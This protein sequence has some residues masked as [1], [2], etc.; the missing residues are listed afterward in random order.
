[1]VWHQNEERERRENRRRRRRRRKREK[2]DWERWDFGEEWVGFCV[3]GGRG[4]A[5][6]DAGGGRDQTFSSV[7]EV[8]ERSDLVVV[9][10]V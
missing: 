5:D 1:M 8:V 3:A 4:D 9:E 6:G 7:K 10:R 2:R